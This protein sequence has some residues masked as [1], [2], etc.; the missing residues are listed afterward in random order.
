MATMPGF[1]TDPAFDVA[2]PREPN[3]SIAFPFS[4]S[5]RM[6]AQA[7][8]A[9][10]GN[11]ANAAAAL[12]HLNDN[13][14]SRYASPGYWSALMNHP[15]IAHSQHTGTGAGVKSS[16]PN[17]GNRSTAMTLQG[18]DPMVQAAQRDLAIGMSLEAIRQRTQ[19][20]EC[21]LAMDVQF[22]DA[23]NEAITQSNERA[24]L[25]LK[26][27]TGQ[28]FGVEPEK[29]KSWWTDQLGYSYQS[30][31][32]VNKPTYSDIVAD[33]NFGSAYVHSACFAGDTLVQT[34]GGP[35]PIRS[36]RVGDRVLSQDPTTG[37][38]S[39]Q[40][41]VA[42]HRNPAA[43]ALRIAL[44]GESI[45]ATGIHRFWIAGKA[46]T[47][48]R[49]LK[50]GDRLR[51]VGGTVEVQS[52]APDRDQPVYNLDVAINRNFFVGTKNLLVHDFSFVS[53]VLEPFDRQSDILFPAASTR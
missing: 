47:M 41:V 51:L 9:L 31:V 45:V 35:R 18:P 52:V 12:N 19:D 8:Q 4:V 29:W 26:T 20:L 39:F 27:I 5:P 13:P 17:A 43:P 14:A 25:V 40:P 7:G 16:D 48:A 22:I 46:W 15:D 2:T 38:L 21:R 44:G 6:A 42:T 1:S 49:D 3:Y 36:I 37:A 53:P 50:P 23:T 30:D 28:D 33:A 32:P 24:L 34:I 10:A 11:P